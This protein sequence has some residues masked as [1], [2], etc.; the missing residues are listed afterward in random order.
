MTKDSKLDESAAIYKQRNEVK[1]DKEKL[2]N[3]ST[4]EKFIYFNDYYRTKTIVAVVAIAA[5]S[6]LAYTVLSPKPKTALYAVIVND[7]LEQES[8]SQL[9]DGFSSYINI[10]PK[11][12]QVMI[13]S[14]YLISES[15]SSMTM[16]SEQKLATYLAANEIDVIIT[17]EAQFGQYAKLG[18]FDNLADRLPTNLYSDFS[19]SFFLS[20]DPESNSI[21]AYGIYLDQSVVYEQA[22]SVLEKPIIGIIVNSKHKT[23][24]VDFIRYLFD[25]QSE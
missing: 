23:A 19:D 25:H 8:V 7:Y 6:S 15:S 13:D 1:T 2:K 22:G 12:Q 5:I 14:S 17:D 24:A 18:Y 4:K 20:T 11:T 3:L 16:V 10:N 21:N 9:T